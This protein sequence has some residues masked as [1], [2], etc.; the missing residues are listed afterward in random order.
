MHQQEPSAAP[1]RTRLNAAD[2]RASILDAATAVFADTGYRRGRTAEVAARVGVSEPVVFQN[3][4]S[5]AALYAA[6]LDQVAERL[7]ATVREELVTCCQGSAATLLEHLLAPGHFDRM[8]ERGTLGALLADAA[9]LTDEP[10]IAEAYRRGTRRIA[11][12]LAAVLAEGQRAGEI[13][14]DVD[15]ATGAWWLLSLL[16]SHRFRRTA[17]PEEDRARTEDRLGE[18]TRRLLTVPERTE[19]P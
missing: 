11:E 4:G 19:H 1:R 14:P 5:K 12:E 6:V 2:R 16:A 8:H 10:R 7:G 18:L 9:A 3:F 17:V 13:A 15:P